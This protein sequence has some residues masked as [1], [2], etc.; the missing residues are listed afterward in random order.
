MDRHFI[1][2]T[3]HTLR[4]LC[5][6]CLYQHR[7]L[8]R[9]IDEISVDVFGGRVQELDTFEKNCL[10]NVIEHE[11]KYI[12]YVNEV[13]NDWTF[14]RLGFIEQAILLLA[15]AEFEQKEIQAAIIIDEAVNLS[16]TYCDDESYKLINGVLDRL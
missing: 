5:M 10:N 9:D 7:L 1:N 12:Q 8:K 3:R 6:T 14:E 4:E 2:L 13:L 11:E 16:K 15:C